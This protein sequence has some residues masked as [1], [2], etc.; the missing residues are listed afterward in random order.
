MDAATIGD[1]WHEVV[2][3]QPHPPWWLVAITGAAALAAV[4]VGSAWHLTR[5]VVTIA[6]EAGHAFA[7]LVTGRQLQGIRLHSDTSGVTVSRG[8]PYGAGMVLTASAGYV[9]PSLL[10]LGGAALLATGHITALLWA[11]VAVLAAVLVMVRNVYGV[12][13]VVITGG[14]VLAVSWLGS[15]TVQAAFA[16]A[17][18]WFLL[19]A[20]ARPVWELQHKRSRG[21]A[22]DSDADQLARLTG[23]PGLMWVLCFGLVA[24]AA[25]VAGGTWLLPDT[26]PHLLGG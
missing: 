18:T 15:A 7:A 2:G 11:A 23:M 16:Y 3:T 6:H 13:S 12:V 9:T 21:R 10:G 26:V 22:P 19:L 17:L 25:L 1:V 4:S 20:G 24:V 14:V 8:K 5:G